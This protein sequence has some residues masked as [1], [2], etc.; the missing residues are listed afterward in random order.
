MDTPACAHDHGAAGLRPVV[1][2]VCSSG[3]HFAE[4]YRLQEAW[5]GFE[6]VW[7]TFDSHD[8]RSVLRGQRMIC[9]YG[10]TNR[11]LVNLARN[12][13][14]AWRVLSRER[15]MAVVS[16]GAGVAV[17]FLLVAR[18]RQIAGVYIE[19]LARVSDLSLSGRITYHLASEFLVQ[20]PGLTERYPRARY[21]GRVL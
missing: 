10:P 2:L 20:W 4:L 15:P 6:P 8:T 7:I 3:G 14:L 13:V 19:S 1:C 16:T 12:T 9:A 5:R 11:N 17:P 21:E 18:L